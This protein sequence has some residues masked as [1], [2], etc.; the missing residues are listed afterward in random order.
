MLNLQ[1]QNITGKIGIKIINGAGQIVYKMNKENVNASR[2]L[3]NIQHLSNGT[4]WL[5]ADHS[6]ETLVKKLV[7]Q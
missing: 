3:I 2:L 5:Q 1:L 7:K 6:G 4:Y